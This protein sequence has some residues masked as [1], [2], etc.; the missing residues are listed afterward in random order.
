M[1]P[2]YSTMPGPNAQQMQPMQGMQPA[3][4]NPRQAPPHMQP[5][6]AMPFAKPPPLN[7][8][9]QGMPP[10]QQGSQNMGAGQD[11]EQILDPNFCKGP[12]M[13]GPGFICSWQGNECDA[14]NPSSPKGQCKM[15]SN[16]EAACTLQHGCHWDPKEFECEFGD[17]PL[18]HENQY[19]PQVPTHGQLA[20]AA[21]APAAPGTVPQMAPMPGAPPMPGHVTPETHAAARGTVPQ[22]APMPVAPAPQYPAPAAHAPVVP[23]APAHAAPVAPAAPTH[24]APTPGAP[25]APTHGHGMPPAPHGMPPAPHHGAP[26]V[27]PPAPAAPVMPQDCRRLMEPQCFGP[28]LKPGEV[29]MYDA[30]DF[31]CRS[32]L[33][34]D[35][36][37]I[38][39]QFDRNPV[40]CDAHK[41]CFYD[42]LDLECSEMKFPGQGGKGGRPGQG[43]WAM[44]NLGP[45]MS[46][47]SGTCSNYKDVHSCAGA[48]QC[49]WDPS[50]APGVCINALQAANVCHVL[51]TPQFCSTN[52]LC[53]WQN[54]MCSP[55]AG[56]QLHKAHEPMTSKATIDWNRN[57]IFAGAASVLGLMMGLML[58]WAQAKYSNDN[59]SNEDYRDIMMDINSRQVV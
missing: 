49:F 43:Q 51:N 3:Q 39:K 27:R 5:T 46:Y 54:N 4:G 26:S 50:A 36:E 38:C 59:T 32:R 20:P 10:M 2:N 55:M 56:M 18:S 58:S 41:D 48:A 40:K 31:E 6:N 14:I 15:L 21:P 28:S 7:Q 11:C 35:V 16:D 34:T 1:Q 23:A 17:Q 25:P 9:N 57:L 37:A 53:H 42:Q 29:C 13:D 47:V 45:A 52:M 24:V 33:S 44:P 22:M 19:A 8:G 12:A 30:E